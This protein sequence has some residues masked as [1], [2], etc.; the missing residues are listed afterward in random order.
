MV[1]PWLI[2][3]PVSF[4]NYILLTVPFVDNPAMPA[5]VV[6]PEEVAAKSDA[7]LTSLTFPDHSNPDT[8]KAV[9]GKIPMYGPPGV[10]IKGVSLATLPT[11]E[12][13]EAQDLPNGLSVCHHASSKEYG[14]TYKQGML[15]LTGPCGSLVYAPH[16]TVLTPAL[17]QRVAAKAPGQPLTLMTC[18]ILEAIFQKS[19]WVKPGPKAAS[20][21]VEQLQ[22]DFFYS[23]HNMGDFIDSGILYDAIIRF[24]PPQVEQREMIG[25][26]YMGSHINVSAW[27]ESDPV[28]TPRVPPGIGTGGIPYSPAKPGLFELE[29]ILLGLIVVGIG[30]TIYLCTHSSS[31]NRD[32]VCGFY[33][34]ILIVPGIILIIT[35][36]VMTSG[37]GSE[38]LMEFIVTAAPGVA[39]YGPI[40]SFLIVAGTTG[41]YL[42]QAAYATCIFQKLQGRISSWY[43]SIIQ[44][45]IVAMALVTW[46]F[47]LTF[48]LDKDSTGGLTR[49]T[50]PNPAT[51]IVIFTLFAFPFH[52]MCNITR[53]I[54][55]M[56]G[57]DWAVRTMPLG[58][59]S[60]GWLLVPALLGTWQFSTI[61]IVLAVTDYVQHFIG[62]GYW[63]YCAAKQI[64]PA[65]TRALLLG[66]VFHMISLVPYII[67][68]QAFPKAARSGGLAFKLVIVWMIGSMAF[69]QA[70]WT[71]AAE[72]TPQNAGFTP[73]HL[74]LAATPKIVGTP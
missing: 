30:T 48:S 51:I 45:N 13:G 41:I 58:Y 33:V 32:I 57:K 64:D 40:T 35:A 42:G 37:P 53:V 67:L 52:S 66:V 16:G 31:V 39:I 29:V 34:A 26:S 68:D 63:A 36:L 60:Q 25:A 1:D 24:L 9:A 74:S 28:G 65:R 56:F 20:S 61:F 4:P 73:L 69:S 46:R 7:V 23:T 72:L 47:V 50:A 8:L 70:N 11:C 3:K 6:T 19:M 15:W 71:K 43:A 59:L 27:P 22:P 5:P 44:L 49:H 55:D 54:F 38:S 14:N 62:A 17:A 12:S 2:R 10:D 21:L 18:T